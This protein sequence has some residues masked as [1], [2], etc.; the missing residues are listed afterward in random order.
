MPVLHSIVFYFIT[1]L[2]ISCETSWELEPLLVSSALAYVFYTPRFAMKIDG[3]YLSASERLRET[4]ECSY[5][6]L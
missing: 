2:A 1:K 5:K 6:C 3:T 4:W